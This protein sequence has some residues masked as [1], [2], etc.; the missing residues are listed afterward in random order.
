M[1]LCFFIEGVLDM[2]ID[3]IFEIKSFV[4][5]VVLVFT[6]FIG[7]RLLFCVIFGCL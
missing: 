1:F 6:V 7:I 4:F 2:F 3:Y 5:N